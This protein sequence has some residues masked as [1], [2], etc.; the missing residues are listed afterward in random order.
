MEIAIEKNDSNDNDIDD[1]YIPSL[2]TG[3][4]S[5]RRVS[6]V[7]FFPRSKREIAREERERKEKEKPAAVMTDVGTVVMNYAQRG[8]TG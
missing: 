3:S 4:R 2:V 7:F 6:G 5:R 8:E 1:K